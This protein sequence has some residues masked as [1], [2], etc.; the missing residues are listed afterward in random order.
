VASGDYN[1]MIDQE[2]AESQRTCGVRWEDPEQIRAVIAAEAAM[3]ANQ[4]PARRISP[5]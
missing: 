3:H 1:R 2:I 4:P 5:G